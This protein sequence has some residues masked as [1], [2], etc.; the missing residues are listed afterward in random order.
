[1]EIEELIDKELNKNA[2]LQRLLSEGEDSF[3]FGVERDLRLLVSN[4][5]LVA[6]MEARIEI[7]KDIGETESDVY[8]IKDRIKEYENQSKQITDNIAQAL[9]RGHGAYL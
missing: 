3:E 2:Q 7:G 4:A 8:K 6:L 5:R 9:K 1:M